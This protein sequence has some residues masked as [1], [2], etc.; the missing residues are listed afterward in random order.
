MS[1]QNSIDVLLDPSGKMLLAEAYDGVIENVQ[2]SAVSMQIKNT[3]LSGDPTAGT[4]EAK[5][6]ANAS[7]Q[8][9]GTARTEGAGSKVK[10]KAVTIPI[11]NDREFVEELQNKDVSLIGVDGVIQRRTANHAVRMVAE[12]DTAFFEEAKTSGSQFKAPKDS[13]LKAAVEK[14]VVALESLKNDY[15]DGID[16]SMLSVTLS[17]DAYSELR[18]YLDTVKNLNISS[19]EN[20][21]VAFHGVKAFNSNRL[22]SG[23]KFVVMMDGSIAQPLMVNEYDAEKIPLSDAVAVESFWYYGTKAVTPD[24]ILWYDGTNLEV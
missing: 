18:T 9:Y 15:I 5:R 17:P 1:R 11:N 8:A 14:A 6:F 13:T 2:K 19:A 23:V 10:G 4:V 24:T 22:P 20:D 16:R 12:L 21:F 7:S 3:D